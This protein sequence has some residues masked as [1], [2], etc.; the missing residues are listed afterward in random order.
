MMGFLEQHI[1]HRK[2][3]SNFKL[4]GD[5]DWEI[6]ESDDVNDHIEHGDDQ[7]YVHETSAHEIN[8]NATNDSVG[9]TE[10][11]RPEYD[12]GNDYICLF[13][14]TFG[15]KFQNNIVKTASLS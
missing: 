4:S 12:Y 2:T 8:V 3:V 15:K 6:Y 5:D 13:F 7:Q 1:E 11:V 10:N 14:V 9:N